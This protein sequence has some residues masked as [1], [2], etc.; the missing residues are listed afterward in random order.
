M[1]FWDVLGRL[2]LVLTWMQCNGNIAMA[3][4]ACFSGRMGC[5]RLGATSLI[6]QW[7]H[8]SLFSDHKTEPDPKRDTETGFRRS[9]LRS[10][11]SNE[12]DNWELPI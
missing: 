4:A 2:L 1:D 9:R 3:I 6:A 8:A 10:Q 12:F 5:L 7:I 11:R